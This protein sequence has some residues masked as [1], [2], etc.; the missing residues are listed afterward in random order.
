MS[1]L[2]EQLDKHRHD[3]LVSVR[4]GNSYFGEVPSDIGSIVYCD[5]TN[6]LA[7]PQDSDTIKNKRIK[8]TLISLGILALIW[9]L[10]HN[11]VV[12]AIILSLVVAVLAIL[13]I[14][15]ASSFSGKDYFVGTEGFATI[16]FDKTRDNITER[17]VY[18]FKDFAEF[19]TGETY[20]K[21]NYTYQG[22]DY[23]GSFMGKPNDEHE[24]E[25]LV[26][27]TGT[28]H[29][30]K[31]KD[32]LLDQDYL[33][34]KEVEKSWSNY[35]IVEIRDELN[36]R[37]SYTFNLISPKE[38]SSKFWSYPYIKFTNDAIEIGG[39][40]YNDETLKSMYF[41]NGNLIVEHM[42]HSK[43]LFGLIEKGQKEEIP[44]TNVGNNKIFLMFLDMLTS[45][46]Q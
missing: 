22:T 14:V 44:F 36:K 15:N 27:Y 13:I 45:P 4:N 37:G 39:R 46:M 19:V 18:Y 7:S 29:Q 10:L 43:K 30:E 34:L 33:F 23:F 17:K 9:V 3:L 24:V 21:Y 41:S 25:M 42:N 1:K 2:A 31:P 38:N 12:W 35:K 20:K 6:T 28:Y 11:A 26:E 8:T 40:V 32:D 5:S 16:K